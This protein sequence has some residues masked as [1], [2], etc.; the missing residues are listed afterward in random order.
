MS[1]GIMELG[2]VGICLVMLI[3][4]GAAVFFVIK[5]VR[6]RNLEKE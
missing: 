6:D 3:L 4:M 2:I 1:V 5:L